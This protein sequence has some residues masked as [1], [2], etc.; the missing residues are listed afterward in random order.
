MKRW[1]VLEIIGLSPALT[2]TPI[3]TETG[4]PR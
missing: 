2:A 4:E 3:E 1:R